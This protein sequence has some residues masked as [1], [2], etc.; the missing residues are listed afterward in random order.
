MNPSERNSDVRLGYTHTVS[1]MTTKDMIVEKIRIPLYGF[2]DLNADTMKNSTTSG[3]LETAV[4][5][6]AP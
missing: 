6:N 4:L 3:A 1:T 2:T 5:V